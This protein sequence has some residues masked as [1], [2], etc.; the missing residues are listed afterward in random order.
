MPRTITAA[1]ADRQSAERAAAELQAAGF[2]PAQ[3][4]LASRER[5]G[6]TDVTHRL[7]PNRRSI[8]GAII[9]TLV[10]GTVGWLIGWLIALILGATIQSGIGAEVVASVGGGIIGWLVGAIFLARAP[11]EESYYR[12]QRLEQGATRLSVA[13]AG[14]DDEARRILARSGARL[15]PDAA[16]DR[17][18]RYDPDAS[19]RATS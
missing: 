16:S 2:A 11:V 9:G 19:G 10:L 8:T 12:E 1:F 3:L 4:D 5:P 6:A 17:A 14:R 18:P 13:P 15:I 7:E